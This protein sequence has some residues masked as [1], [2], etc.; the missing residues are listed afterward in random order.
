MG[1]HAKL[2]PSSSHRWMRCPG[3]VK[4]CE[5]YPD[6][7]SP[8]AREGTFAHAVAEK[9][10]LDGTDA[11]RHL[12]G[13]SKGGEFAVDATMVDSVQ[14]YLD[15]VRA[16]ML[17]EGAKAEDL[18]VE[19]KVKCAGV[20]AEVVKGTADV[21]LWTDRGRR[22]HVFDFKYG[23]GVMVP[24]DG[25]S[26]LDIYGVGTL[27]TFGEERARFGLK[28]VEIVT[29]IVQPRCAAAA[30]WRSAPA[31]PAQ[32]LMRWADEELLPAARAALSDDAELVPGETQCRFCPAKVDCPALRTAA[33]AMAQDVFSDETPD[34][35]RLSPA[36][37]ARI[38]DAAPVVRSYLK[39]VEERAFELAKSGVDVP[40][41]KL[42]ETIGNRQWIDE[43]AARDLMLKHKVDPY[44]TPKVR[45]PAQAE[46]ALGR[47]LAPLVAALVTKPATGQK[48][49]P[50][51]DKRAA[52]SS[53]DVF[54]TLTD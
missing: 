20:L 48:L 45:S 14:L 52:V 16:T 47:K 2:S 36:E 46:K 49:A 40:G 51:A 5:G 8:A 33:L 10:L 35:S 23:A 37:L 53:A 29:H 42:V 6:T 50:D 15:A 17:A 12:G 38:V 24:A 21:A 27:V 7:G 32:E 25:N 39:A 26:Q 54:D 4:L 44:E 30:P 19:A 34:A 3:S 31:R 43:K 28:N 18:Q 1:A 41:Y 9:C 11:K 13:V 22:L